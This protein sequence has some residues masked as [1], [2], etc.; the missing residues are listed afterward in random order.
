MALDLGLTY[1]TSEYVDGRVATVF[2]V[3]GLV[4]GL[5]NDFTLTSIPL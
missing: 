3:N 4:N 1:L 5:V 2:T